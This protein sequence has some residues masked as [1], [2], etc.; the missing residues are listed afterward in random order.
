MADDNHA[1]RN[2][3]MKAAI[4]DRNTGNL[5][6]SGKAGVVVCSPTQING[7]KMPSG[8]VEVGTGK[9]S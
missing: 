7:V 9:K 8:H 1:D 6:T 4:R 5:N 2:A 3:K